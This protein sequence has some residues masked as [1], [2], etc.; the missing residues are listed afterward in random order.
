[1]SACDKAKDSLSPRPLPM[2][3]YSRS[4]AEGQSDSLED[5]PH[6]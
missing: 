5:T 2:L 3:Q 6:E 1:M 4:A